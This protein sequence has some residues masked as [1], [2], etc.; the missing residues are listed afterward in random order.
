MERE[1]IIERTRAGLEAARRQGRLGGRKRQIT[2]V[3]VQA[4]R[5][6]L[7][8]GTPPHE[9]ANSLGVC[10]S[11]RCIV[12]FLHLHGRNRAT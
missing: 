4:A 11:P 2:D 6:L 10:R 1:L 9:V 7:A 12:G 5:K 3:K 8:S